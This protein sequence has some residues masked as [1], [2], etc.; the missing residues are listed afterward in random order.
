MLRLIQSIPSPKAEPFKQWLARVGTERLQEEAE[1][2]RAEKRLRAGTGRLGY[3]DRWIDRRLEAIRHRNES[4][5]SGDYEAPRRAGRF[6][7]LTDT[8]SVG[9]FDITT[10]E[11]RKIK[12][13]SRR[14]NLQDSQNGMELAITGLPDEAA[15]RRSISSESHGLPELQNDCHDAG[16]VAGDA[17]KNSKRLSGQKVVSPLN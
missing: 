2:T 8:L 10:A 9:A 15:A 13:L 5:A 4:P 17:P 1:L 16:K 14:D 11:H 7:V 3:T 12:G 6:A